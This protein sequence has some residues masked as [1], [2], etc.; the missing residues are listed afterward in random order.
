MA[1]SSIPV[2]VYGRTI[3]AGGI[4]ILAAIDP[5]AAVSFHLLR[6]EIFCL[7]QFVLGSWRICTTRRNSMYQRLLVH[8]HNGSH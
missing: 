8:N 3:P 7:A 6:L 5:S 1:S 4:P 2:G